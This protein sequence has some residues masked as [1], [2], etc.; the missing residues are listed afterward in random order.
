MTQQR[1]LVVWIVV[2]F[3]VLA[4]PAWFVVGGARA[5]TA[6]VTGQWAI[7]VAAIWQSGWLVVMTRLLATTPGDAIKLSRRLSW[8]VLIAGM[9]W[10]GFA[11]WWL[12]VHPLVVL[13]FFVLMGVAGGLVEQER[14]GRAASPWSIA[15]WMW[16]PS[17]WLLPVLLFE[18]RVNGRFFWWL[19]LL[20]VLLVTVQHVCIRMLRRAADGVVTTT[21]GDSET[22]S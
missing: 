10:L 22:S 6:G 15:V 3:A 12:G 17:L 9:V 13:V 11:A 7:A 2:V 16:N 19:G 18:M 8:A 5:D 4:S 1:R 14:L 21:S 20:V